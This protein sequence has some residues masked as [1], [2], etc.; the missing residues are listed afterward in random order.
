MTI[1]LFKSKLIDY[2]AMDDTVQPSPHQ[3]A[4]KE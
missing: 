2:E 4:Q 3:A 1:K